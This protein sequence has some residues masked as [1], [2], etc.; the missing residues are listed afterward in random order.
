MNWRDG[1]LLADGDGADGRRAPLVHSLEQAAG[2]AGHLGAGSAAKAEVA[3]VLVE[4]VRANFQ[5]HFDG[6]HIAGLFQRFMHGIYHVI[7][8]GLML[9][10]RRRVGN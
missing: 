6:G 10:E 7:G 1:D 3:D 2:F 4:A 9:I 8:R 5:R